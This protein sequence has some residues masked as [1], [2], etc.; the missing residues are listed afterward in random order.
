M[1]SART[2]PA[3]GTGGR[4]VEGHGLI[5]FASVMLVIIGCFNLAT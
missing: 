2:Q 3:R 4:H 1:T 5:L